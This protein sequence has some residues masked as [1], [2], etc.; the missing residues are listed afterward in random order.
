MI[1]S[2]ISEMERQVHFENDPHI[3]TIYLG[4]GTPSLLSIQ[5]LRQ[6][7]ITIKNNFNVIEDAEIT[8]EVN[9]DDIDPKRLA[10]WQNAGINRLSVGIQ[11][12]FSA[13]LKWMNRAHS[14]VDS[15]RCLQ[16]I[17][18]AG[19]KNF[20]ADLIYGS[21]FLTHEWLIENVETMASFNVPH[22][23]CYA[24]TVENK[25]LLDHQVKKKTIEIN[26]E[27]QSQQFLWLMNHLPDYGYEQYEISN[28]ARPGFKSKHNRS[29][30]Q[31]KPYYGFGPS[32]HAFD[33]KQNRRWNIAN[34]NLYMQFVKDHFLF[35]EEEILTEEQQLNESIMISLRTKDGINVSDLEEKYNKEKSAYILKNAQKYIDT[36]KL[37]FNQN[38]LMLTN[39]GKL[40]ADGIASD[41]FF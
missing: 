5:E 6:I 15:M 12:F 8:L 36:G 11:T 23:S 3:A 22:L 9:P 32:A 34:N 7:L 37:I 30:W 20:S 35:F 38:H 26:D 24:L 28:F 25:T 41:L 14:T 21:P 29:Y 39:E 13:E 10:E 19:F 2:I 17:N 16:Q 40:F 33:G 27:H 18:E 4:G 31:G 1:H